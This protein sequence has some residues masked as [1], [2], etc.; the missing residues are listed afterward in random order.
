MSEQ[1]RHQTIFVWREK[2]S[3]NPCYNFANKI[4]PNT[5]QLINYCQGFTSCILFYGFAA[6]FYGLTTPNKGLVF[7]A[8]SPHVMFDK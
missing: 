3:N 4:F 2:P 7:T 8:C 5:C 6:L 1:K